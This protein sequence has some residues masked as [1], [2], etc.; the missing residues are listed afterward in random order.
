MQQEL[1]EALHQLSTVKG[2]IVAAL[3]DSKSSI[4]LGAVGIKDDFH[5]LVGAEANI[6]MVRAKQRVVGAFSGGDKI[7]DILISLDDEYHLIHPLESAP[8]IFFYLAVDRQQTNLALARKALFDAVAY[9]NG[10]E[11]ITTSEH[12]RQELEELEITLS[13]K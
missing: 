10:L 4:S 1:T 2:F 13:A 7:E 5:L 8:E 6:D 3:V 12:L 11:F 9:I